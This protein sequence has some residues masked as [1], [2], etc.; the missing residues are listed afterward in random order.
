MFMTIS[1]QCNN[2]I[3]IKLMDVNLDNRHVLFS[4]EWLI[5]RHNSFF[6]GTSFTWDINPLKSILHNCMIHG[7]Y[8]DIIYFFVKKRIIHYQSFPQGITCEYQNVTGPYLHDEHLTLLKGYSHQVKI[9]NI[10][11]WHKYVR[12][13][14]KQ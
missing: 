13:Y 1:S 12:R 2:T 10:K 11:L 7:V 8:T 4:S 9:L 14:E 3:S 6:W 5:D